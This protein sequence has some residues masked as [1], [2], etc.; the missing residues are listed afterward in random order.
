MFITTFLYQHLNQAF[1]WVDVS[2]T[3]A[4]NLNIFRFESKSYFVLLHVG[5]H[6]FQQRNLQSWAQSAGFHGINCI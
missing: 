2:G 3:N 4:E 5:L 6:K 1:G